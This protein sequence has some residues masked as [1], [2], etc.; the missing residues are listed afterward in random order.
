MTALGPTAACVS[1]GSDRR[2][3]DAPELH[4]REAAELL[5]VLEA[6]GA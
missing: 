3:A 2:L 5:L 6:V 4:Y 1:A